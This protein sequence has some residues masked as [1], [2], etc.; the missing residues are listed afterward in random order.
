VI[1][2]EGGDFFELCSVLRG[3]AGVFK[4]VAAGL[5]L[6]E[7]AGA[8]FGKVVLSDWFRIEESGEDFLDFREAVEPTSDLPPRMIVIEAAV[9]FV[10]EVTGE[11]GNFSCSGHSGM[12]VVSPQA[13]D[14][15]GDCQMVFDE[16]G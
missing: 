8:P 6:D 12:R 2:H 5:P 7:A 15:V 3:L 10:A 4:V 16:N 13:G 1:G 14:L 9:E 11:A